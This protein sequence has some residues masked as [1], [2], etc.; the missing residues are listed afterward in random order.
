MKATLTFSLPDEQE[1]FDAALDGM[2]WKIV[3]S[4]ISEYLR[5]ELKYKELSDEQR[6]CLEKARDTLFAAIEC[7][8][9]TL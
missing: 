3:V 1:E 2:S 8:D 7:R 6:D 9:L 5:R 4:E